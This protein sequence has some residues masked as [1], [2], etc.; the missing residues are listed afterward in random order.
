MEFL[1]KYVLPQSAH[2]MVL[3]KYLMA[4]ALLIFIPYVGLLIGSLT[5]S[6]FFKNKS[7]KNNN[8]AHYKF[9]KFLIDLVTFNK[10]SAFGLGLV[11]LLSIAFS[12]AQLLHLSNAPA[13]GYIILSSIVYIAAIIFVYTYKY[14]FHMRDILGAVTENENIKEEIKEESSFYLSRTNKLLRKSGVFG[15]S[16]LLASVYL[17][18]GSLNFTT[19]PELWNSGNYFVHII[20]S[21]QTLA[22]FL[23]IILFSLGFTA[24]FIIYKSYSSDA[25]KSDEKYFDFIKN[26]G[27]RTGLVISIILP[28]FIIISIMVKSNQALSYNLFAYTLLALFVVMF[29]S[30]LFYLMIRD[31]QIRYASSLVY[32][33]VLAV[34]FIV[35]QEYSS[36]DTA[37]K[38]QFALLA[39]NYDEYKSAL[40]EEY[41]L[42]KVVINGADIYNGKCIACHQFDKKL[43]GPPYNETLPKYEGKKE[44]LVKFILN[45]VKVNPDYPAMPNQ[46]LKPAEAEAVADYLL[47]T[48]KK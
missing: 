36:L 13:A 27:L 31:A 10:V 44:E 19:R 22:G 16:L 24:A 35:M 3:L 25:V 9:S 46:G 8:T 1:D 33:F 32:L 38:K 6:L 30:V 34:F 15:L 5:F 2:H 12:V 29:I 39:A 18:A 11:P 17:F 43:V 7:E 42:K 26:F 47:S 14:S 45:P 4:L 28:L 21:L 37:T 41:G 23:Q 40:E 48:Y 20:F